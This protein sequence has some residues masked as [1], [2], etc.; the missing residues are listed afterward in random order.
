MLETSEVTFVTS[1]FDLGAIE[2][3]NKRRS[4]ETYIENGKWLVNQKINL[5]IYTDVGDRI[6][7]ILN[8]TNSNITIKKM[9]FSNLKYYDS[10]ELIK[11]NR[12]INPICNSNE[13]KDT[14]TYTIVGWNK[15]HLINLTIEENPFNTEYFGWIDFGISHVANLSYVNEDLIFRSVSKKIK[16]MMMLNFSYDILQKQKE[17]NNNIE[18]YADHP[19]QIDNNEILKYYLSAF[20][21]IIAAGYLS[22][23]RDYWNRLIIDIDNKINIHLKTGF[24][25]S[26]EQILPLCYLEHPKWF[27]L[28]CGDYVDIL[29]NIRYCRQNLSI[30]V[31]N[32][33]RSLHI[34]DHNMVN[35]IKRYLA[36]LKS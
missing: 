11:Y 13:F 31:N 35:I 32:M 26:E 2:N 36:L 6:I 16:V 27:D 22:G 21:G 19:I 4:I 24:A 23:H 10:L 30:C 9:E 15:F 18:T 1:L 33:N 34:G 3:N 20:R 25:S 7:S 14:P 28:Y 17:I 12:S 8:N 5:V 29:S